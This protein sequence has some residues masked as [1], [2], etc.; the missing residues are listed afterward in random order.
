MEEKYNT[1]PDIGVVSNVVSKE[2]VK[3]AVKSIIFAFIAIIIYVAIRFTFNYAIGGIVAIMHDVFIMIAFFSLFKL[4]V[5]AIFIAAL[6]SIIGYSIND[7]IVTFD[8][9]REIIKTKYNNK[10]K[11]KKDCADVVN[12]ALRN[13][14]GRSIV[15]TF[16]TLC[17]VVAL[18][19]FGSSEII[20]FNIALLVGMIAG[21]L[22]SIFLAC[23]IWYELTKNNIK[24]EP[25]KHWLDDEKEELKIK[26]INS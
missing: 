13:V 16:T 6:L 23:Q 19:I 21:V 25:K 7:T 17:P 1:K 18:I 15:T 3:N 24:K 11:N 2:L 26:G 10:L 4:E 14:L 12:T 22:S 8:R 9:M 20:N 5:D